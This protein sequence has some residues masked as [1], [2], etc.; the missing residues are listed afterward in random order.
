MVYRAQCFSIDRQTIPRIGG[1]LLSIP[2]LC[3]TDG[4]FQR[5][6]QGENVLHN[7]PNGMQG[8]RQTTI[9]CHAKLPRSTHERAFLR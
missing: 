9:K 5:A 1:L 8:S 4:I 7:A 3:M 2:T 6:I